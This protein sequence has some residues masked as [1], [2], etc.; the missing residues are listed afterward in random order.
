MTRKSGSRPLDLRIGAG[1]E[2][3][4]GIGLVGHILRQGG[5]GGTAVEAKADPEGSNSAIIERLDGGGD[6]PLGPFVKGWARAPTVLT[7]WARHNDLKWFGEIGKWYERRKVQ[8]GKQLSAGDIKYSLEEKCVA[9]QN[10]GG[11]ADHV[12]GG[13]N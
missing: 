3:K 12:V 13:D 11:R 7:R 1:V 9:L 4:R 6:W 2:E 8:S 10:G 5:G